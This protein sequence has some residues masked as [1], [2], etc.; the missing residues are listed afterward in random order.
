MWRE[1]GLWGDANG[2]G[3]RMNQTRGP[4]ALNR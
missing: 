2:A 1:T 4:A 3:A